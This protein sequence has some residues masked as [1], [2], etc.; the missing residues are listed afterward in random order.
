[1]TSAQDFLTDFVKDIIAHPMNRKEL[2]AGWAKHMEVREAEAGRGFYERF[3][4]NVP[5]DP[6]YI[7][8][9]HEARIKILEAAKKAAGIE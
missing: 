2:I 3:K 8:Y 5:P 7:L 1:M 4:K 9:S 6:E